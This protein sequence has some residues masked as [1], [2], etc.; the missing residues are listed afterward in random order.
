MTAATPVHG[1]AKSPNVVKCRDCFFFNPLMAICSKSREVDSKGSCPSFKEKKTATRAK[2][3]QELLTA[4]LSH[5][6]GEASIR[7]RKSNPNIRKREKAVAKAEDSQAVERLFFGLMG[8]PE[9]KVKGQ[10][11]KV[12]ERTTS[13]FQI[14]CSKKDA[15]KVESKY[16]QKP[17]GRQKASDSEKKE[18]A[19]DK[20]KGRHKSPFE[21]LSPPEK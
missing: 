13:V 20:S 12:K 6:Q 1:A 15:A 7:R 2:I 18:K 21:I 19:K 9:N 3:S 10:E 5:P 8:V 16:E 14:L 4:A 11:A 17:R